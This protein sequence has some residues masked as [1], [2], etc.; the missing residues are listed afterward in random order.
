LNDQTFP[1]I[2]NM[3]LFLKAALIWVLIVFAEIGNGI[4]RMKFLTKPLGDHRA[5]Q[6]STVT[7]CVNILLI[8]LVSVGWLEIRSPGYLLAIGLAWTI[9][10]LTFE[11]WLGRQVMKAPWERIFADFD[12]RKGNLLALGMLFLSLAPLLAGYLRGFLN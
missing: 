4:F 7:G 3:M 11:I 12:L 10:M 2:E 5:R 9:A 1:G 6:L 8:S